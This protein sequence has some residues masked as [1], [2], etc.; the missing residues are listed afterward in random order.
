[1][2]DKKEN[3]LTAILIGAGDRGIM[4]YG[5]YALKNKDKLKFIAVAEPI[6]MRRER[7]AKMHKISEKFCFNTWEDLLA[8][9]KFADI[10]VICTQDQMHTKPAITALEKG[11]D[12]LLEKPIAHNLK[13]CVEI[14]KKVEDTGRILGVGHVLRYTEFFSKIHDVIKSG[15]LGDIVNITHRENVSWY[16]MAHSFVRGN[17]RNV[18]SSSPMILAKCCH[19]LDL[20]YWM[21][22]ALPKKISSIGNLFH[23]KEENAPKGAPKYC[24]EGCPIENKCLYYAPRIYID[25]ELAWQIANKG[26]RRIYKWFMNWR[27]YHKKSLEFFAKLIPPLKRLRYWRDWPVDVLYEDHP[28]DYSDEFKMELLKTSPYGRCVYKCDNDVVDHQMVLIE[29]ENGVTANLTMHGFSDEEGRTLRIDGTKATL[30]GKFNASGEQITIKDH[31]SGLSKII[32][33]QKL[34]LKNI[35]HGGGD[36]RLIDAF[37]KSVIE[38]KEQ[39]LTNAMNSLESHLMAFA[40]EESRLKNIVIDMEDFRKQALDLI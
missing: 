5:R 13:E 39:P 35:G 4:T 12:V 32:Y 20:I 24:V 3:P 23:F 10:A 30:T 16:H 33:K 21:I 1:M 37:I 17:W 19:D 7:F 31:F 38:R 26:E 22:G 15:V 40:A 18:E 34:S 2:S 36:M 6:K 29:F 28:E 9:E 8:K 14:V 27:K 11:Y 25:L